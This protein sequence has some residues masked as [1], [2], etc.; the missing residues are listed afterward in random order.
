M[1]DI[2]PKSR[3]TTACWSCETGTAEARSPTAECAPSEVCATFASS[4]VFGALVGVEMMWREGRLMSNSK[5]VDPQADNHRRT[6]KKASRVFDLQEIVLDLVKNFPA[7]L[8]VAPGTGPPDSLKFSAGARRGQKAEGQTLPFGLIIL[9]R[10]ICYCADCFRDQIYARAPDFRIQD[11]SSS[12]SWESWARH[13]HG[14]QGGER[15]VPCSNS[16][17]M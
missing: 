4:D 7:L 8:C 13:R 1:R 15:Q 14:P 17:A 16:A 9:C 3:T 10:C 2:C 6:C 5:T 11:W 12:F